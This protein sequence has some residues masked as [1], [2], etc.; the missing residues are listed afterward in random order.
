MCIHLAVLRFFNFQIQKKR[1]VWHGIMLSI[2]SLI[3]IAIYT[4]YPAKG[5]TYLLALSIV[6]FLI[7]LFFITKARS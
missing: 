4:G 1:D 3:R 5:E 7:G 6:L 2:A